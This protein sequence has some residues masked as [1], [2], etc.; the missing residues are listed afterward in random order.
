MLIVAGYVVSCERLGLWMDCKSDFQPP[1]EH[2]FARADALNSWLTK[3]CAPVNIDVQGIDRMINGKPV[4]F[5]FIGIYEEDDPMAPIIVQRLEY[6]RMPNT[7]DVESFFEQHG[8]II[9]KKNFD[10]VLDPMA[11]PA[12]IAYHFERAY[13][14]MGLQRE[15]TEDE[16]DAG[17]EEHTTAD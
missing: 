15:L 10:T 1:L 7:K 13:Q 3:V 4:F 5:Y 16:K 17:F 14:E 11:N 2:G 8:F 6:D 12:T 9:S